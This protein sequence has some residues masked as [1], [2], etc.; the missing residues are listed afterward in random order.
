MKY[1]TDAKAVVGPRIRCQGCGALVSL[2][3]AAGPNGRQSLACSRCGAVVLPMSGAVTGTADQWRVLV[4]D[5]EPD[6]RLLI[7]LLLRQDKRF[8]VVGEAC[9]GES[10]VEMAAAHKP[11][12]VLLDI[13]MPGL[14]GWA[15]LPQIRESVPGCRVVMCSA[16]SP[17]DHKEHV[18]EA[19]AYVEKLDIRDQ[20]PDLLVA[21]S[22]SNPSTN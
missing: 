20:I 19:D 2:S 10:A 14:N 4:V 17:E 5:D 8:T 11:D 13:A 7:R 6:I 15:A 21:L 12:F 9:D 18:T 22:G 16:T 3:L 1:D